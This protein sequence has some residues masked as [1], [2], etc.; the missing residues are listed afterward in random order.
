MHNGAEFNSIV[1]GWAHAG[2]RGCG[3]RRGRA[4]NEK[5]ITGAAAT[6]ALSLLQDDGQ[7]LNADEE[8]AN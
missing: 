5:V 2:R 1:G 8:A 4:K 7:I 6:A 3:G